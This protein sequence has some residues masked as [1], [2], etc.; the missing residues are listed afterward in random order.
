[1]L[2]EKLYPAPT[3]DVPNPAAA[4]TKWEIYD[5]S[6]AHGG[7]L[8]AEYRYASDLTPTVGQ[9]P[10]T[11]PYDEKSVYVYDDAASLGAG[12]KLALGRQVEV[13]DFVR[14]NGTVT[15]TSWTHTAYDPATGR[16]VRTWTAHGGTVGNDT[17]Y[18]YDAQ[19]RLQDVYEVVLN[20][21]IPY[22]TYTGLDANGQPTF[23]GGTV[24]TTAYTYDG[25]GNLKTDALPDGVTTTYTYDHL[26]RLTDLSAR[27]TTTNNLVFVQHY[28]LRADGLRSDV[29]DTRYNGDGTVFSSTQTN[30]GYDADGR[31]ITPLPG[32][33]T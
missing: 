17:V 30:W 21:G 6:G 32:D 9:D 2:T 23:T 16:H 20:G 26:N 12:E 22:A 31:L 15:E 29:V 11:S 18:A 8:L 4:R 24:P 27:N 33:R 28:D 19:G 1:M 7:R 3:K 13:D 10:E 5:N 14:Q 25:A